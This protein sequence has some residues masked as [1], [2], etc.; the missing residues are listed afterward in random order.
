M[1]IRRSPAV[2]L[3][4]VLL[5]LTAC[6]ASPSQTVTDLPGFT[7]VAGAATST[8]TP[9]PPTTTPR[10]STATPIPPTITRTPVP[11]TATPVPPTRTPSPRPATSTRTPSP[12][13]STATR[14]PTTGGD[15]VITATLPQGFVAQRGFWQVYFTAPTGSRDSS[16]Y[17]GG[18]DEMLAASIA[19]ARQTIDMVAYE[20]NLPTITRALLDAHARG[21][22]VRMVTDRQDGLDDEETTLDQLV[23]AGIPIVPDTR[24]ALMHDKFVII[25]STFVWTGSMNYTINDVYRNNNN[26]IVLRS[27]NA[28]ANYQAEFDEM[29]VNG[30][31]GPR[32]PENTP[33]VMF[34][35]DGIPIEMYFA[36]ETDVLPVLLRELNSATESI[37]FMT[38]S[39]TIDEM[40]E[41]ILNRF[42]A[43]V[44]VQGIFETV[45]S[46]T[47]FSELTPLFCAGIDVRQDGNSFVL[48]HKVIIIDG[49]T[50]LTGSFNFSASALESNDENL[51]IIRDP[52]LANQYLEEFARRWSE[53]GAPDGLDC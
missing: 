43:G 25:D 53:A 27:R 37:R 15:G 31:F 3:I 40:G 29:F 11:P 5:F 35:Q 48:H 38:F 47:Q 52:S 26:A 23:D 16:T 20:F 45:G 36:P 1:P 10:P 28:V 34:T 42:D 33:N 4:V 32:S 49:E 41:S 18:V 44:S 22:R 21:V 14:T 17:V 39:F 6:S 2:L 19:G 24:N 13:P 50:V 12:R 8:P 9:R 46:E 7:D 30:Q 51:V